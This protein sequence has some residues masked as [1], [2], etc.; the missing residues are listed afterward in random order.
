M[1]PS[2][3]S[4]GKLQRR[5]EIQLEITGLDYHN[6]QVTDYEYVEMDRSENDEMFDL[7]TS[8]LIWGLFMSTMMK[9]AVHLGHEDQQNL[10]AWRNTNFEEMKTLF[11]ITLRLIVEKSFEILN[12]STMMN[13]F[14]PWM[15]STLCHGQL[16]KRAKAEVHVY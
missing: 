7:K 2:Q 16:I 6:L 10:I 13:D 4:C 9:S 5:I 11:E 1:K 14:S 3:G 15:R 12:F 8:A